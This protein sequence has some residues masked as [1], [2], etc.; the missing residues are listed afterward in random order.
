MGGQSVGTLSRTFALFKSL[1]PPTVSNTVKYIQRWP[2]AGWGTVRCTV[3]S[4]QQL[5]LNVKQKPADDPQGNGTIGSSA[6]GVDVTGT[7]TYNL[8]QTDTRPVAALATSQTFDFN[9]RG[10]YIEI[11][12]VGSGT[13][14][15]TSGANKF[16]FEA[17]LNP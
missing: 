6:T 8:Q 12:L 11:E 14:P 13:T 2:C 10:D 7:N 9:I 1:T 4:D 16:Q 17:T 3:F 5:T 15:I